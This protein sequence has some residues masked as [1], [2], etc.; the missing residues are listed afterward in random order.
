VF[1]GAFALSVVHLCFCSS[2]LRSEVVHGMPV[3]PTTNCRDDW[4]EHGSLTKT[5]KAA[6]STEKPI[7]IGMAFNLAVEWFTL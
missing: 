3:C 4:L 5:A 6:E 7:F 1:D 2:C